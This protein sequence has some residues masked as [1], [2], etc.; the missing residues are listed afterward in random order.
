MK[1]SE[2]LPA[3]ILTHSYLL[4]MPEPRTQLSQHPASASAHS[5]TSPSARCPLHGNFWRTWS[6]CPPIPSQ[7]PFHSL[8]TERSK[9]I[10][11][12][13]DSVHSLP[14]DTPLR[15]KY[16]LFPYSN[17]SIPSLQLL[18]CSGQKL[19]QMPQDFSTSTGKAPKAKLNF[20][21]PPQPQQGRILPRQ[22][23]WSGECIKNSSCPFRL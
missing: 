7:P 3:G 2:G 18:C 21:P 1:Y 4:L 9:R 6:S 16:P 20:P 15:G 23:C 14:W 5:P 19:I 12:D 22:T 10:L 8:E 13:T 11:I 17:L